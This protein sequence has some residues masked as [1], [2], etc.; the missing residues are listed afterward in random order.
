MLT[1]VT[2]GGLP[3]LWPPALAMAW[4]PSPSAARTAALAESKMPPPAG[5]ASAPVPMLTP[6]VS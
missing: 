5:A 1:P 4:E 3:T 2:R 6:S